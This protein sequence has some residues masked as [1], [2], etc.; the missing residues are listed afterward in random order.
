MPTKKTPAPVDQPPALA[1][2]G[3]VVSPLVEQDGRVRFQLFAPHARSV[4]LRS[5]EMPK[6][7]GAYEAPMERGADGVWSLTV[8]PLAPGIYDYGFVLDGLAIAD[9]SSATLFGTR[10]GARGYVEVPAEAGQPRLDEWRDVPHGSLGVHWYPS[11]G[12]GRTRRAHVYT[13]PGYGGDPKRTYPVLYLLHGMGDDDTCWTQLGKANAILDNLLADAK[14]EPMIVVMPDGMPLGSPQGDMDDW[15]PRSLEA[16]RTDLFL[17][18]IP[19][20]E[21]AYRA[22]GSRERR[23]IAGLS[24]G[25]AHTIE[26]G[27]TRLD[28]FAWF[29]CM[30]SAAHRAERVVEQLTADPA[31]TNKAISLLWLA[32]GLD[33]FLLKPHRAFTDALAEGGVEF[34]LYETEGAHTW[35]KWRQYLADLAPRLFRER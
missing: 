31:A 22:G 15:W 9:P 32:I 3:S 14:A 20:A 12:L 19:F 2:P 8:G 18:L 11:P 23:A 21:S 28:L 4:L 5:P 26:F 1:D 24:M 6:E 30:S 7:L 29:G 35:S 27:L 10:R 33:D 16:F 34:E 17:G 25:G 13:P